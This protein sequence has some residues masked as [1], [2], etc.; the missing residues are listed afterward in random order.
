MLGTLA[1]AAAAAAGLT[2]RTTFPR[3]ISAMQHA[4]DSAAAD[5]VGVGHFGDERL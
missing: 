4:N 2:E 5:D 3:L 1:A